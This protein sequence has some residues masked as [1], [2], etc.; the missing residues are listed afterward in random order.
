MKRLMRAAPFFLT[1]LSL[2]T[3]ANFVGHTAVAG[4]GGLLISYSGGTLT[5]SS[6][7]SSSSSGGG[8]SS[9]SSSSSSGASSSSSGGSTTLLSYVTSLEDTGKML[10]GSWGDHFGNQQG[11]TVSTTYGK[12][13]DQ[14]GPS[15]G[16][17]PAN[18]SIVDTS[19]GNTGLAPAMLSIQ[20]PTEGYQ[21]S[22]NP[23]SGSAGG[24]TAVQAINTVNGW[25]AAGGIVAVNWESASPTQSGCQYGGNA[26]E[27]LSSNSAS[28][29]GSA[30]NNVVMYGYGG[31]SSSPTAGVW[32]LSQMLKNI[33]PGHKVFLRILHEGNLAQGSGWWGTDGTGGGGTGTASNADYVALFQQMITYLRAQGVTNILVE[34]NFN[35]YSGAYAQNDPGS[36]YRD[37]IT[38]DI[39]DPTTQ[40]GVEAVLSNTSAGFTW[41]QSQNVPVFIAE[42]GVETSNN[43]QS[44]LFGC[45][46]N[47]I[48]D[49]AIQAGSGISHLVATNPWNQNWCLQCQSGADTYLVNGITRG[50]LPTLVN[51]LWV[52]ALPWSRRRRRTAAANDD[53]FGQRRRA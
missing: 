30:A 12:Y 17:T 37:V 38:G 21:S 51:A 7:S 50:Q 4:P 14:M 36:S 25:L 32:G 9:S 45:C 49:Q 27:F 8:G 47:G 28:T 44:G 40:S 18:I 33:T 31:T 16:G 5:V 41:A 13:L 19:S 35:N 20:L 52:I 3:A 23:C 1:L 53:D 43:S 42:N 24:N 10:T 11:G 26:T 39:Y 46:N 2:V 15:T 48:W 22:G 6:S 29:P 34:Y